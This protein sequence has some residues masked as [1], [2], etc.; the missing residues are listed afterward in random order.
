MRSFLTLFVFLNEKVDSEMA[1]IM[2]V[3]NSG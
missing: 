2:T 1:D 3:R